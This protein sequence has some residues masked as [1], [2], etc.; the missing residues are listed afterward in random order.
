MVMRGSLKLLRYALTIISAAAL[1]AEY[2][3]VGASM[4]VSLRS[5][6]PIG[7]SPYTSSVEICINLFTPCSRALSSSTCVP[8]TFVFVNSYELP[9]LKS[10]CDCAAKWKM[11]SILCLRSTR[12][13]SVGDVMSPFSK[14]KFGLSSR[15]LVL[16]RVAQ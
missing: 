7:T 1:L 4:L 13:T 5:A 11:V 16:L 8:Y 15:I 9:K 10:T 14:V 3:L 6:A 2:G 12:F